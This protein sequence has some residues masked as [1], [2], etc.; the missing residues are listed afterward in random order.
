MGPKTTCLNLVLVEK[1][2]SAIEGL[3]DAPALRR[4]GPKRAN[5]IRKLFNLPKHSDN[6]GKK[7]TKRVEV[8]N[9]DVMKAVI[10]RVHKE[11][12]GVKFFK[13]PKITR[14]LTV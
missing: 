7:N 2:E 3:T 12:E 10:K 1:G 9:I 11:K 8:S 4:L 14:L 6:I 13:A 5:K